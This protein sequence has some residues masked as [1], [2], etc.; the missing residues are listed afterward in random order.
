MATSLTHTRRGVAFLEHPAPY[1]DA[2]EAFDGLSPSSGRYH[3]KS[4]D[5]WLA[6]RNLPE[7][8]HGFKKSYHSGKYTECFVFKNIEEKERFYGFLCHPKSDDRRYELCVLAVYAQKKENAQDLAELERVD[9]MRRDLAVRAA[10][11][12]PRLFT[13][14]VGK[15]YD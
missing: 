7:R 6:G 14:G 15:N 9:R 11:R 13:E 10:L 8:F 1:V 5:F 12:D 2:K 4:F 3:R